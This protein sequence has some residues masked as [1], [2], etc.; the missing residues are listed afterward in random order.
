MCSSASCLSVSFSNLTQGFLSRL[1]QEWETSTAHQRVLLIRVVSLLLD[2]FAALLCVRNVAPIF[3]SLLCG[4]VDIS[5]VGA[6]ML[7]GVG[8]LDG[9]AVK[10]WSQLTDIMPVGSS[11]DY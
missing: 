11:Y 3:D 7:L 10:D 1:N 9:N 6:K 8:P 4:L 2:F 5:L